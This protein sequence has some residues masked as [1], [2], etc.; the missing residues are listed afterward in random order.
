L[1]CRKDKS[2]I[3]DFENVASVVFSSP[4]L[5]TVGLSEEAAVEKHKDVDIFTS[6][7]TCVSFAP[8]P[9]LGLWIRYLAVQA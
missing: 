2:A 8:L 9:G 6:K 5:A 4:E 3:P 1:V 7:F